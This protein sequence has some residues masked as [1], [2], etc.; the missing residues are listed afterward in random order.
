MP[1][2]VNNFIGNL[3]K[4]G[5]LRNNLYDI[6]IEL[7]SIFRTSGQ[8]TRALT[9]KI[10]NFD[11][12]IK[13]RSEEVT[14][15]GINLD[16]TETR[17]YGV[18][19]QIKNATNVNFSNISIGFIETKKHEIYKFFYEWLTTIFDFTGAGKIILDSAIPRYNVE[20]KKY[21]A[22]NMRIN[23]YSGEPDVSSP[24]S[25]VVIKDVFPV[26]MSEKTLSWGD[27]NSLY[28]VNISLAYTEWFIEQYETVLTPKTNIPEI[29]PVLIGFADPNLPRPTPFGPR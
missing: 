11:D 23:V 28:K 5:V 9:S 10:T 14:L 25:I 4:S 29:S 20:Y 7:P 26:A 2:N 24:V 16:V 13:F 12:I 1:F 21:Y 17:R 6:S 27:T 15:P 3:N 19:P 18:G 22:T 8:G